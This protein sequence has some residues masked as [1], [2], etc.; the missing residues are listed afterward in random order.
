MNIRLAHPRDTAALA[1]LKLATFRE[2]FVDDFAIP[3]PPADLAAFEEAS[4]APAVVAA[5]LDDVL[6][7]QFH[8]AILRRARAGGL[9]VNDADGGG[10][11][12]VHEANMGRRGRRSWGG[13]SRARRA[14]T[15]SALPR[16]RSGDARG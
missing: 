16:H 7:A 1:R 6:P 11:G 15:P 8:H 4:Y 10:Q 2:T 13:R 14:A 3:Y 12:G 5:V 9:Q